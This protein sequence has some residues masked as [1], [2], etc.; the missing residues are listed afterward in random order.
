[1]LIL[2]KR[3]TLLVST[4]SMLLV[5]FAKQHITSTPLMLVSAQHQVAAQMV[6]LAAWL[7]STAWPKPADT[8]R[9]TESGQHV[10]VVASLAFAWSDLHP[11]A[12]GANS[13]DAPG[14][15]GAHCLGP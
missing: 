11:L 14:R 12:K 4:E 1:M 13:W 9:E 10:I 6:R 8:V 5:C 3:K 2:I 7:H 15:H